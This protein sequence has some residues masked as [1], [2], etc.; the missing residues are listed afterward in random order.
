ML[1]YCIFIRSKKFEKQKKFKKTSKEILKVKNYFPL[2]RNICVAECSRKIDLVE[3][4]IYDTRSA[5]IRN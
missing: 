2:F 5:Q 3:Y 4:S 1:I